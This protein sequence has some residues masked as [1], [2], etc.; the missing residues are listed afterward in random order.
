LTCSEFLNKWITIDKN[1]SA[2]CQGPIQLILSLFLASVCWLSQLV[3]LALICNQKF[4]I[5]KTWNNSGFGFRGHPSRQCTGAADWIIHRYPGHVRVLPDAAAHRLG[6]E[7]RSGKLWRNSPPA[8]GKWRARSRTREVLGKESE[9]LES[10]KVV[11]LRRRPWQSLPVPFIQAVVLMNFQ[12]FL[13]L[14]RYP[15]DVA[16][17]NFNP[18]LL[19]E[20]EWSL[21]RFRVLLMLVCNQY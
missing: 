19:I 17:V 6:K 13:T 1:E 11:S 4:R 7:A 10:L 3:L 16:S 5:R 18:S 2:L 12:R 9:I 15:F 8:G 20:M 21:L 14:L